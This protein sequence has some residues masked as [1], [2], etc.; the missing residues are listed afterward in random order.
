MRQLL[1]SWKLQTC[2]HSGADPHVQFEPLL[3]EMQLLQE[4]A[5]EHAQQ[6]TQVEEDTREVYHNLCCHYCL[7]SLSG[8]L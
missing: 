1:H 7:L 2:V 3:V 8:M 4:N 5:I 6:L